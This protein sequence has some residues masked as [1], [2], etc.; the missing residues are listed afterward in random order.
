[1]FYT[2]SQIRFL[3][4]KK[5]HIIGNGNDPNHIMCTLDGEE[6]RG[7]MASFIIHWLL[8]ETDKETRSIEYPYIKE[9]TR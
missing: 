7:H 1:M 2:R 5:I 4:T 6:V 3:K 9:E 8:E